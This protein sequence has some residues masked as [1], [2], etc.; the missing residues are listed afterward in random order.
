MNKFA[1]Y[2]LNLYSPSKLKKL[3]NFAIFK[4]NN[5]NYFDETN[6]QQ[7]VDG[8]INYLLKVGNISKKENTMFQFE[9]PEPNNLLVHHN[10]YIGKLSKVDE[11]NIAT[12][13]DNYGETQKS[14][15][16]D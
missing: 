10:Q 6:I 11:K 13:V 12:I 14:F 9:F 1:V 3:A 8:V 5:L 4:D 7:S 2:K 16:F 15:N